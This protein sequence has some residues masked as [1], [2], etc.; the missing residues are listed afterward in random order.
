MGGTYFSLLA[1]SVLL[2]GHPATWPFLAIAVLC[3]TAAWI[4][5]NRQDP[6]S[7]F[8]PT[9]VLAATGGCLSLA[10]L[11]PPFILL[12][13]VASPGKPSV[14]SQATYLINRLAYQNQM[15][16]Q[17]DWIW[18]HGSASMRHLAR[19]VAV[20]GQEVEWT[21]R[22]WT[23][24]G[25]NVDVASTRKVAGYPERWNFRVPGNCTLVDTEFDLKPGETPAPLFFVANPLIAGR[26]WARCGPFWERRLL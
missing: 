4:D 17:G 12:S 19:V 23:V 26:V 15:P 20:G 11:A 13:L 16:A 8:T 5:A 21:G 18:I 9:S 25:K 24:D 7:G 6:F 2:W 1:A 22:R 10:V 14:D 3:Q